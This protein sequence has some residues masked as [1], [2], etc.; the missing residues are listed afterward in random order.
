MTEKVLEIREFSQIDEDMALLKMRAMIESS[1]CDT[2]VIRFA[3]PELDM[4]PEG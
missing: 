4:G 1:C 3:L 2:N